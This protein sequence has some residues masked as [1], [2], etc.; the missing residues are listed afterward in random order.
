LAEEHPAILV[1]PF[2]VPE[3]QQGWRGQALPGNSHR[4]AYT[5]LQNEFILV[6]ALV[7]LPGERSIRHT[8][9]TGELN[10]S[11]VGENRPIIRWNPPGVAH[12]GLPIPR[13]EPALETRVQQAL[14]TV[15]QSNPDL[16]ALLEEIL[17]REVRIERRFDEL[18]RPQPGLRVA[19]DVLFP[20]FRTT[21]DDP[22]YPDKRTI[23]GQWYD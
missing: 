20:P 4:K 10:I 19:I 2:A 17:Q 21:I 14:A 7:V 18:T 5:V 1:N 9:E 3:E 11:Y 16:T 13:G 23:T 8:H 6:T 22:A 15:G 12:G